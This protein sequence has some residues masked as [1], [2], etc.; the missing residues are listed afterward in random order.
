MNNHA[1][2]VITRIDRWP[3]Y[4]FLAKRIAKYNSELILADF[5]SI[6]FKTKTALISHKLRADGSLKKL[7]NAPLPSNIWF[8]QTSIGIDATISAIKNFE[9]IGCKNVNS[10]EAIAL[11]TNKIATAHVLAEVCEQGYPCKYEGKN[12][13]I[14]A[15]ELMS[16]GTRWAKPIDSSLGEGVMRVVG[17]GQTAIIT[18]RIAGEPVHK[19]VTLEGLNKVLVANFHR[20]PFMVQEDLGSIE[21]GGKNFELRFIMRRGRSG[22]SASC[23]I[24]RAGTFISNPNFS[25]GGIKIFACSGAQALKMAFPNN[26]EA[27]YKSFE[28]KAR[29]ACIAFQSSLHDPNGVNELGIDMTLRDSKPTVIEINSIP[30]LTFVDHAANSS[31]SVI[32]LAQSV[33]LEIEVCE[34][35]S[36]EID[37]SRSG[38]AEIVKSRLFDLNY[39]HALSMELADQNIWKQPSGRIAILDG[40]E[41]TTYSFDEAMDKLL[42]EAKTAADYAQ[43]VESDGNNL[44]LY[45]ALQIAH[46]AIHRVYLLKELYFML[47]AKKYLFKKADYGNEGSGPHMPSTIVPTEQILEQ[48]ENDQEDWLTEIKK[49][50]PRRPDEYHT[51]SQPGKYVGYIGNQYEFDNWNTPETWD[52]VKNHDE[53]SYVLRKDLKA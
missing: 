20:A 38:I 24:A 6:D 35:P 16:I 28:D 34:V 29:D 53:G 31:D 42:D 33:G 46:R 4:K 19:I 30:D 52:D 15:R 1:L 22:W 26:W 8:K 25:S 32:A 41:L 21:I 48:L 12:T 49:K 14:A 10:S 50:L 45:R 9:S 43:Q 39:K 40:E 2:L 37:E 27:I 36:K 51:N 44:K 11:A 5:D 17:H 18:K 7:A 13:L 23:R 47:T 3:E